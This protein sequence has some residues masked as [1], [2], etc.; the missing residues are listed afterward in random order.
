MVVP[1]DLKVNV[2]SNLVSFT[3]QHVIV[4]VYSSLLAWFHPVYKL[5][6]L[7]KRIDCI[8]FRQSPADFISCNLN[9]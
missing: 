1:G 2:M 4:P 5:E 8:A 3:V 9:F 6:Y 7:E